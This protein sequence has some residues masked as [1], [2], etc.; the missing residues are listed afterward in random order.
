MSTIHKDNF[1][2][3][4]HMENCELV[5]LLDGDLA[6]HYFKENFEPIKAEYPYA[7]NFWFFKDEAYPHKMPYGIMD[8]Y[9]FSAC[10]VKDFRD[11]VIYQ[12]EESAAETVRIMKNQYGDWKDM[13]RDWINEIGW[14]EV[15]RNG[16]PDINNAKLLYDVCH[17]TGHC[18]GDYAWVL[19]KI[20]SGWKLTDS[21]RREYFEHLF[22]DAP[23]YCR[24]EVDGEE[25]YL[26]DNLK[27]SYDWDR[28]EIIKRAM[29]HELS[30][31]VIEWL[32]ENLP[33]YPEYAQ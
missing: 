15:M 17:I 18:Q 26:D 7:D 24:L 2:A 23:I 21:E 27:D 5:C 25:Y 19:F 10:S 28:D 20:D 6:R 32:R 33:E 30:D 16:F 11:W 1:D 29:Q 13:A 22:Y 31:K 3:C 4:S 9:D 8:C 14:S 12:S